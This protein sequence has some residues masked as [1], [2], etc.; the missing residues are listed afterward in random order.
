VQLPAAPPRL[1]SARR[2]ANGLGTGLGDRYRVPQ[3][4]PGQ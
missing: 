2:R 1:R 4:R 3:G